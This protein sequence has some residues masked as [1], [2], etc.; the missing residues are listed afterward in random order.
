MDSLAIGPATGTLTLH[1]GVEGKAAKMG[2]ALTIGLSDWAAEV[3]LEQGAPTSVTLRAGLASFE[4]QRGEGGVKPLSDKDKRT[5]R[6]SAL[7]SLS[8]DKHPDVTFASTAVQPRDG[9]WSIDGQLTVAG[10]PRPARI[11]VDLADAGDL[12]S[13]SA[14]VPVVQ[15]EHGVKPYSAM[16]G[17][18][19]LR[20]RVDVR[21]AATVPR[22]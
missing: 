3:T 13:L 21:V 17:A 16:M 4:V 12:V 22:P 14:L 1:T 20:D 2:H 8:A 18:L 7:N 10:V 15:T 6:D 5:I 9:G 19:K 11:D